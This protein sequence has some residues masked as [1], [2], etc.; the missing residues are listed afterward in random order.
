MSGSDNQTGPKRMFWWA[1]VAFVVLGCA[2]VGISISAMLGQRKL[3]LVNQKAQ[4]VLGP[5][6]SIVPGFSIWPLVIGSA[7]VLIL[8]AGMAIAGFRGRSDAQGP[9]GLFDRWIASSRFI[10]ILSLLMIIQ[11]FVVGLFG[12]ARGYSVQSYI[13]TGFLL[14]GALLAI[15]AFGTKRIWLMVLV[16][17]IM[18]LGV[19]GSVFAGHHVIR[20]EELYESGRFEE[21][22]ATLEKEFS[23][24][25]NFIHD[26]EQEDAELLIAQSHCQLG[27]Y[28]EAL[29]R[30]DQVQRRY[31]GLYKRLASKGAQGLREGLQAVAKYEAEEVQMT[32]DRKVDAL[33]KLAMAYRY[34]I[35]NGA[36]ALAT[37]EKV[38]VL[39]PSQPNASKWL[40]EWRENPLA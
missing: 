35:R 34:D 12:V 31:T 23:W 30:Y 16:V 40:N 5:D 32:V 11:F 7:V 3:M 21:A 15:P 39:D 26:V 22:L 29:K 24:Y 6:E 33:I 36:L 17:W 37:L 18:V 19:G 1:R 14:V 4:E 8:G 9:S 10:G 38:L 2:T 25:L 13:P 28:D 27:Q 20:G